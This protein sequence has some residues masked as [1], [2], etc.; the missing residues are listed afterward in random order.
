[1]ANC[2]V[3]PLPGLGEGPPFFSKNTSFRGEAFSFYAQPSPS[4]CFWGGLLG[5]GQVKLGEEPV[6]LKKGI[7]YQT[8]RD[9]EGSQKTTFPIN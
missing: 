7:R 9:Q 1:L 3:S 6:D 4:V 5:K 8:I 2:A